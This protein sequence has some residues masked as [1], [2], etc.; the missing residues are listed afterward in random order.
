M[1]VVEDFGGWVN[2]TTAHTGPVKGEGH[3]FVSIS[4]GVLCLDC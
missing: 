4:C 3:C 2:G 1:Q